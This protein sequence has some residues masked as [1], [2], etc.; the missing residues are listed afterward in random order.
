MT[1]SGIHYF[2]YEQGKVYLGSTLVFE[3]EIDADNDETEI[4]VVNAFAAELAKT[5]KFKP[6]A[7]LRKVP[8]NIGEGGACGF[9]W[10]AYRPSDHETHVCSRD[11]DHKSIHACS[12]GK[13]R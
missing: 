9:E 2:W 6:N 5:M 3:K 4:D 12:C 1:L 13:R 7:T 11:H 10:R 8:L